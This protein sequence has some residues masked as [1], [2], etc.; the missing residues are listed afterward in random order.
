MFDSFTAKIMAAMRIASLALVL[1]LFAA[2]P[3]TAQEDAAT[4]AADTA[5]QVTETVDDE[6]DGFDW[7]LLG[8]LGLLGLGGLLRKRDDTHVTMRTDRTVSSDAGTIR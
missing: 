4:E 5:S 2:I 7:G 8:L 6:D 3:V 1:G